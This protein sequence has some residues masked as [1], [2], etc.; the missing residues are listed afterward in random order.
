MIGRG[1]KPWTQTPFGKIDHTKFLNAFN[2]LGPA[3]GPHTSDRAKVTRFLDAVFS[4]KDSG[5]RR[6][7]QFLQL[8]TQVK[9]AKAQPKLKAIKGGGKPKSAAQPVKPA[10][11]QAAG[12]Q[13]KLAE[14]L[15]LERWQILAGI[16][17]ENN[18]EEK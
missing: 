17:N 8:L 1:K 16:N 5:D 7:K 4:K 3:D 2:K 12:Q 6:K 13:Q 9:A 15:I 11:K 18:N 14:S 10:P